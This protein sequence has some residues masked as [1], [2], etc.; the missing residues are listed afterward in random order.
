MPE[1]P[2]KREQILTAVVS[3]LK[4]RDD[5]TALWE[6]GAAAFGRVDEWSD[7][8]IMVAVKSGA[9][10]AVIETVD[11]ALEGVAPI[12]LRYRLP[13]PAW[14][15]HSQVFHMLEGASPYEFVDTCFMD[16]DTERKFLEPETHGNALVHFD[17]SGF[18]TQREADA[19]EVRERLAK[20]VET[21]RA[22]STLGSTGA[23]KELA[24][25]NDIEALAYYNASIL[26]PLIELLRIRRCSGR[27][28]FHTR[29][30][31]YDLPADVM[32]RLLDSRQ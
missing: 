15:G 12:A 11:L 26:R 30:I 19:T 29:Y 2:I 14:H 20:R 10:D 21:I 16:D 13:E 3:A 9:K 4:A 6:G 8:D 17:R 25:G 22:T 32:L 23:L 1:Y 27:H 7:L 18:V 31:Q 28:Q 24:R 5:V